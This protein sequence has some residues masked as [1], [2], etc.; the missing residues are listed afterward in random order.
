MGNLNHMMIL[1]RLSRNYFGT[2]Q[3]SQKIGAGCIKPDITT[4]EREVSPNVTRDKPTHAFLCHVRSG[5]TWHFD[6]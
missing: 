3:D 4:G 6:N 5:H 2:E 1:R